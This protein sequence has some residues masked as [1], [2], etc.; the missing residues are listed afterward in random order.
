[1]IRIGIISPFHKENIRKYLKSVL[2]KCTTVSISADNDTLRALELSGVSFCTIDLEKNSCFVDILILDTEDTSL[3][4]KSLRAVFP[5]TRLI[6]NSDKCPEIN[7]PY[8]I[9]YGFS[10]GAAATVSSVTENSF[11]MYLHSLRRLD[12]SMTDEGEYMIYCAAEN[13]T[14]AL[15]AVTCAALC[16]AADSNF[17]N[18]KFR[19]DNIFK[20]EIGIKSTE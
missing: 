14:D 13:I 3:I 6:Y 2:H 12:N 4:N 11:L 16:G 15:C 18:L 5:D 10:N 7:H 1:M 8:A 19:T 20:C 9:S 17:S